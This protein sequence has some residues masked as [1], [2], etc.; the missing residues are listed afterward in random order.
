MT[1]EEETKTEIKFFDKEEDTVNNTQD[2]RNEDEQEESFSLFTLDEEAEDPN[3]LEIQSFKFDF[4]HKKEEPQS[5]T[6]FSNTFSEEKPVEF[7]FFVNEP[8][9]NE[10]KSDFGQPKAELAAINEVNQLTE[11]PF[12]KVEHFFQQKE[13]LF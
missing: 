12:Q 13:D 7:S 5:N 8:V 11:E 10:P 1:I 2:W 9:K 6:A 4:D 3:D